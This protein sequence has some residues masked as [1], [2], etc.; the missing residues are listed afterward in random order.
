MKSWIDIYTDGATSGNGTSKAR[1][2]W[3]YIFY[4]EGARPIS[5]Y[6][7]EIG[8]TNNR[9]ELIAAI[10]GI[11]AARAIYGEKQDLH[12][13]SDSAYLCNCYEQKWYRNWE[14]N[15]WV[16]SNKGPVANKDLW[17]K[18]IPYFRDSHIL[19]IKV[20]G[21]AGNENNELVDKLAK[22]GAAEAKK[23]PNPYSDGW[24]NEFLNG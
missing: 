18:L 15:G 21:H 10:K 5:E 6:G 24:T 1:G 19:F 12:I 7:G 20:K 2:G 8:T 3:A 13:I 4:A 11:E 23:E 16:N 9:M 14:L 22:K 17:E